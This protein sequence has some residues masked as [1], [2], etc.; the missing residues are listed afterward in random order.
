M[1]RKDFEMLLAS[2][3]RIELLLKADIE[4]AYTKER[5]KEVFD[6]V[7]KTS[8]KILEKIFEEDK[9]YETSNI[10]S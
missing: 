2:L 9:E 8:D 6:W 1:D 7:I 3:I 4:I 5:S 10:Q